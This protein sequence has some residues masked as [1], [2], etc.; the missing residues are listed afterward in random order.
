MS[1]IAKYRNLFLSRA[2]KNPPRKRLPSFS[3]RLARDPG[4]GIA[5]FARSCSDWM[6]NR[7]K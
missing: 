3:F 5:I 6:R 7:P 4:V 2:S 1:V